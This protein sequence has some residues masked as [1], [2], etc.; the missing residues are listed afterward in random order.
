MFKPF[1]MLVG[2]LVVGGCACSHK[3]IRAQPLPGSIPASFFGMHMAVGSTSLVN[4]A[5]WGTPVL[6]PIS[7]GALGKCVVSSWQ[8]VE[9]KPGNYDWLQMDRCVAWAAHF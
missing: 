7:I 1:R 9:K 5:P 2:L 4:P 3:S 8:Y 6:E